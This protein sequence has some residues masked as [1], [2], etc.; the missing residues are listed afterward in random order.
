M[1]GLAAVDQGERLDPRIC[2][3]AQ[4]RKELQALWEET[5]PPEAEPEDSLAPSPGSG[6]GSP[7][8]FRFRPSPTGRP[9]STGG[10]SRQGPSPV[11]ASRKDSIAPPSSPSIPSVSKDGGEA[12]APPSP[13]ESRNGARAR[14]HQVERLDRPAVL[15]ER[16]R[17]KETEQVD[18]PPDSMDW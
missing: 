18:S 16:M 5:P 12:Q 15:F 2:P 4:L 6:E 14:L 11:A 1:D 13:S 10:R 7:K 3:W 17:Q 8:P 9:K